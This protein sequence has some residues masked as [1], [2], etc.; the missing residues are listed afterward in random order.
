MSA[1]GRL[2]VCIRATSRTVRKQTA[3]KLARKVFGSGDLGSLP[4]CSA[5]ACSTVSHWLHGSA[6]HAMAQPSPLQPDLRR[7]HSGTG[8]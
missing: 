4:G 1:I 7:F 3:L 2:E 6:S 8:L 5:V